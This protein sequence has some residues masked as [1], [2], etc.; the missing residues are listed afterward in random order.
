MVLITP[1]KHLGQYFHLLTSQKNVQTVFTQG[2]K[3]V[4]HLGKQQKPTCQVIIN[5]VII[6]HFFSYIKSVQQIHI[7]TVRQRIPIR[8][9]TVLLAIHQFIDLLPFIK[10]LT[11][12]LIFIGSTSHIILTSQYQSK[13]YRSLSDSWTTNVS[14]SIF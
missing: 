12:S 6:L 5:I 14:G 4:L 1:V 8:C 2:S 11:D 3:N 9:I 13:K 7:L 10:L